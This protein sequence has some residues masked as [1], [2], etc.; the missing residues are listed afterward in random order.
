M[1]KS[2]RSKRKRKLRA[3]KRERYAKKELAQLKKVLGINENGDVEMD[4]ISDI[5]TVTDAKTIQQNKE[6]PESEGKEAMETDEK[7]QKY[8]KKTLRNEHGNYPIWLSAR[9]V[10]KKA[11]ANRI[12]KQKSKRKNIRNR[13]LKKKTVKSDKKEDK[14][15]IVE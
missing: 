7:K 5:A 2:L 12:K 3:I 15:M 14:Q 1:A 9:E 13:K 6:N 10:K 4:N 11:I 8:S